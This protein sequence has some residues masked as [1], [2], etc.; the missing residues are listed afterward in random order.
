VAE[1]L[2]EVRAFYDALAPKHHERMATDLAKLPAERAVLAQFAQLV[3]PGARV[4]DAGCGP[5]RVTAHL[6]G[7]G[8]AVEG[9]DLSPVMLDLARAVFP[10]LS[11]R[12]GSLTSLDAPGASLDGI[13]SW[14]SL[15]HIPPAH[16]PGVMSELR[17]VLV[18]GG[19]AL[20]A[21]QVGDDVRH[22]VDPDGSDIALDFHRLNPDVVTAQLSDAGLERVSLTLRQPE[23]P[24]ESVPQALL[25]ARRI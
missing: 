22:V 5:G 14:Y 17:R 1:F 19:F 11:F 2:E 7:L 4:L 16:R 25:L 10:H 3:G 13:L 9:L 23:P 6:A 8:L 20:L 15:I 24:Y 21:F 12:L 18:P